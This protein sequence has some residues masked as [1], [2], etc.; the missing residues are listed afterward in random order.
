[1]ATIGLINS[2][3]P[4]PN[5]ILPFS[6]ALLAPWPLLENKMRKIRKK[7][8]TKFRWENFINAGNWID[9]FGGNYWN[10]ENVRLFLRRNGMD[11]PNT[12]IGF[13]IICTFAWTKQSQKYNS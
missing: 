11:K 2:S 1:V 12:K 10:K 7:V 13:S 4:F 8:G 3:F 6:P 9:C 5:R